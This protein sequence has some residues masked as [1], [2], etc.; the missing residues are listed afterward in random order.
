MRRV[1]LVL[2]AMALALLLTSGVA[3]AINELGTNGPDTLRGTDRD[4]NLSGRG[5]NDVL[6]GKG[7]SDNLLGGAGKDWVHGGSEHSIRG[8]DKNQAWDPGKDVV[9]TVQGSDKV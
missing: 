3:W 7:G 2:G 4:D 8:V 5:G 9:N 1:V 6:F